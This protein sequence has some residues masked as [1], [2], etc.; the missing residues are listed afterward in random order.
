MGINSYVNFDTKLL[1]KFLMAVHRLAEVRTFKN[2]LILPYMPEPRS[3]IKTA[4]SINLLECTLNILK[5][6]IKVIFNS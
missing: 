6:Y 5:R 1:T 4:R 2:Y 3:S